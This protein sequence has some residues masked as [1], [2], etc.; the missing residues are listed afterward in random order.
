MSTAEERAAHGDRDHIDFTGSEHHSPV[1]GKGTQ[2]NYYGMSRVPAAL[3]HQVGVIPARANCFQD[4]AEVARLQQALAG[5]GTAVVGQVLAGMGG[6][7]KTQL[8]ADYARHAQ[9][10]GTVDVLVWITAATSTAVAA[11]Y[12]Q[13]GI[14]VLGADPADPHA[15][16]RQFLAWL[17][18]KVGANP[19]R[20]LVVLDDVAD[21]VDLAG[22]WPPASPHGRTLVTTRRRDAA[23][24][25]HGR[26]LVEVGLFSRAEAVAYLTDVL[27]AHGHSDPADQLGA[28]ADDLGCLPLA[29]SQ[30]AAYLIDAHL[31][32]ADYRALLADRATTLADAVPDALPDGQTVTVAAAWTLSLDRADTLRPA[33]LARP[34]L[35]LASFLD[36]NGIPEA[37]PT[38]SPALACL[39][40]LRT[41][42]RD[43][44]SN[45]RGDQVSAQDATDAM[46]CLHRLS[47]ADHTPDTPHQAIR[48]HSLIQRSIRD[49]L[50]ADQYDRLARAAADALIAAWPEV[51]L[52]IALAQALRANTETLTRHAEDALWRPNAHP[53]LYR[54]GRS[55][56][57][58]GQATTALAHFRHLARAAH[59][60]LGPD[61]PD[62]LEARDNLARWRGEAGD[63]AGAADAF[64]ELLEH[65]QRVLGPDHNHS[66]EARHDLA[67]WRGEAGDPAGA[68]AALAELA[69][70]IERVQ[71]PDHL[72]TLDVR[73]DL[74]RWRGEAGDPAGA[75]VAFA[76]L[77][78]HLLRVLGPDH[79]FTLD[80]RHNLARWR[81]EAGDPA[82]AADASFEVLEHM[83]RVLGPDH[84]YTLAARSNLARWRGEAGDPAGAAAVLAELLADQERVQGPDHPQTLATRLNLDHWRRKARA[85]LV[86]ESTD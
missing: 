19:C 65:T 17:E 77:L 60:H 6:V 25:G 16:A 78:E 1:L 4:R 72:K 69:P 30:A 79:R 36:A 37:V 24:T 52:D 47:L 42:G 44:G 62:T 63:P 49:S 27:T 26:R 23:L 56:G 34:M 51:E 31:T 10:A 80:A 5:G 86:D 76:E 59:D 21:P 75:A 66:L 22:W 39:A 82:G 14:E 40:E 73:H 64:A 2:N 84:R 81:G 11:G 15:A 85:P 58:S 54:V 33:G 7:G 48:V 41:R 50:P 35:H 71:G 29:L 13:A 20:W 28:L 61:H 8:A 46:R 38:A 57:E 67:S 32:C 18:P 55:L 70:D 3:P 53:V 9:E 45:G 43:T 83:L 74:A 68:A 12:G